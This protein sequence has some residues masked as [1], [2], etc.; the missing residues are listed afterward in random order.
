MEQIAAMFCSINCMQLGWKRFHKY[1]CNGL[2]ESLENNEYDL[3]IQRIVFETIDM[4]DGNVEK[5][6]TLLNDTKDNQS[7]Y[8]FDLSN[9]NDIENKKLQL[10]SIYAL[11]RGKNSDE[12]KD[13]ASW[14]VESDTTLKTLCKTKIQ[15]DFLKSF[16]LRMMGVMDRN[17]Y[18]F[19]SLASSSSEKDVEIGTGLFSFASL[20]N[21]SCSPN[22][23]RFFVDNKQVYV[24]K[25]PIE[26]GQQLFVG[27]L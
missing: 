12:D 7:I 20:L 15:Q 19:Y 4:F 13:M 9:K 26:A 14:F 1:E 22:L 8:D 6:K 16:I 3:M 11:K 24:V 23:Y 10:K 5:L 17:S 18:I 2:E 25:K 21:H 27:Y